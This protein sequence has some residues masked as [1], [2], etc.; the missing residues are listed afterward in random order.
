MTLDTGR[1]FVTPPDCFVLED[2]AVASLDAMLMLFIG[3]DKEKEDT[4]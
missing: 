4:P 2:S 3:I 1:S